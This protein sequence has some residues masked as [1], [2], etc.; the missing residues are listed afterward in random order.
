MVIFTRSSANADDTSRHASAMIAA[1][2]LGIVLM[3]PS[4]KSLPSFYAVEPAQ[5]ADQSIGADRQDEQN[6]Q[7]RVHARHVENAI[8]LDDQ[9]SDA[10]VRKLGFR[11]QRADQCKPEPK[12]YAIDDR[13]AHGWQVNLLNHL[14]GAGAK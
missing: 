3:P 4:V 11:K 9:K 7:H 2:S 14:Q 6:D 13:M 1:V 12:S 8:S 10:L 5:C